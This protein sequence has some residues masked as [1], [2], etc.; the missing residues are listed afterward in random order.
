MA[1]VPDPPLSSLLA[2]SALFHLF[3]AEQLAT[4]A[5]DGASLNL[6]MGERVMRRGEVGHHVFVV[7]RGRVRFSRK[8]PAGGRVTLATCGA[9]ELL[10]D[11]ALVPPG[12]Y[13]ASCRAAER[14]RLLRLPVERVLD[15][16]CQRP[17]VDFRLSDLLCLHRLTR[18]LRDPKFVGLRGPE[19]FCSLLDVLRPAQFAPGTRIATAGA[20]GDGWFY[21]RAGT[22]SIA[23]GAASDRKLGPGEFFGTEA[24][25][26]LA[27][28][29]DVLAVSAMDCL[30]LPRSAFECVDPAV[31]APSLLMS[32]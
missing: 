18:R 4:L 30:S 5:A 2:R 27:S 22:V 21:L 16:I 8:G 31:E 19:E 32:V 7:L 1:S 20:P 14:S 29:V 11:E 10:G 3:P 13:A 23:A 25:L 12:T 24:L 26:G 15:L 17:E 6:D 28:P 9:G